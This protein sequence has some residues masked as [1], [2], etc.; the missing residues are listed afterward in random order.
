MSSE[1]GEFSQSEMD[2]AGHHYRILVESMDEGAATL[3]AEG[4]VVY[5]N[6]RFA[7]I[8]DVPLERLIGSRLESLIHSSGECDIIDLLKQAASCHCKVECYVGV[9]N[10]S[11]VPICLSFSPLK[12]RNSHAICL[13]A[14]DLTEQKRKEKELAEMNQALQLEIAQRKR[15]EEALLRN[16]ESLRGLSGRLLRLQDE[17]RRRVA[18]D[19]HDSTGQ[20]LVALTLELNLLGQQISPILPTQE[21]TLGECRELAEQISSEIRTLSYLLHPPLLDEVGLSSAA[22]WFVDGFVRRTRIDVRLDIP[23]DLVRPS[24]EVELTLFRILQESLTNVHRHSGS[25]TAEVRISLGDG[26]VRLEVKDH[27][28]PDRKPSPL[29]YNPEGE[30][31]GVG[32]RGMRERVRQLGGRL[33]LHSG[34]DGTVV[35]AVLPLGSET[36]SYLEDAV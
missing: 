5:A 36:I 6:R 25:S 16:A 9:A 34:P 19:L 7:E 13:I 29:A 10:G 20:K 17:E 12:N 22:R 32:I 4:I 27:G 8:I 2:P 26:R 33:K 15:A 21:K 24:Q 30:L 18:R 23:S 31:L 3:T 35:D 28:R 11:N 1:T 14:T